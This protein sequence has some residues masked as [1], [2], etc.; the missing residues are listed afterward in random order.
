MQALIWLLVSV[1]VVALTQRRTSMLVIVILITY[2]GVPSVAR[3]IFVGTSMPLHPGTML[4]L[5]GLFFILITRTRSVVRAV[6]PVGLLVFFFVLLASHAVIVTIAGTGVVGLLINIIIAPICLLILVLLAF[7]EEGRPAGNQ[8]GMG[9]LLVAVCQAVLAA[10]QVTLKRTILYE[11]Q[12]ARFHWF[13]ADRFSRGL[14]TLDSALD[15]SFL[16]VIAIPLCLLLRRASVRLIAATVLTVGVFTTQSRMGVVLALFALVFVIVK[17]QN[18]K[19]RI[20]AATG[21]TVAMGFILSSSVGQNFL[22]RAQNAS[23]STSRRMEALEF[24]IE[25]VFK[26]TVLGKG[27]NSSYGL[28]QS[29]ILGS[30]L[31]NGWAMYAYDFGWVAAGLYLVLLL[32]VIIS[33]L[34]NGAWTASIMVALAV[35]MVSGYSSIMTQGASS[36]ITFLIAGLVLG[37]L[38]IKNSRPQLASVSTTGQDARAENIP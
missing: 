30:S 2:L 16:L 12:F 38:T 9:L 4:V 10:V 13:S 24:I 35:I 34:R 3:G 31:E 22:D 20:L 33:G 25:N 28:R 6:A 18:A 29:S 19:V 27:L 36:V 11:D 17:G 1:L 15:L 7:H 21:M 23:G 14:G 32:S 5:L 26:N 8:I 37:N